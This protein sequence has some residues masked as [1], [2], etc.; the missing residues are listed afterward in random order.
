LSVAREEGSQLKGRKHF[1]RYLAA[2]IL[3]WMVVDYT[4]AFNPDFQRWLAH[5]PGIWLFYIGYPLLFSILIFRLR[6]R[7]AKLF[8]VT[9]FTALLMEILLFHNS[10]LFTFPI[11][12][13]MLPVA[14]LLYLLITWLPLWIAEGTVK[15]HRGRLLPLLLNWLLVAF[16]NYVNTAR[17]M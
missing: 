10:L 3:C 1:L 6:L 11:M 16:L 5:M 17:T 4:T 2:G 15:A 9:L 13:V 14:V 12:L 7:G 8:L